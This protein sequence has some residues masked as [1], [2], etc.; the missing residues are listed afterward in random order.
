M[1][2]RVNIEVLNKAAVDV[3]VQNS[4]A[5]NVEVPTAPRDF[6]P[7]FTADK[8]DIKE[9]ETVNFSASEAGFQYYWEIEDVGGF[10]FKNAKSVSHQFI[11]S[12]NF[13]IALTQ[14]DLNKQK[15]VTQ[16]KRDFI[17][18]VVPDFLLDKGFALG[19]TAG[20]SLRRLKK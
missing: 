16:I 17:K 20:Y 6:V 19:A 9:G 12:G 3:Q 15:A 14:A 8:T 10:V 4:N 2:Q 18:V 5:I 1:A 7:R 11:D 13:D